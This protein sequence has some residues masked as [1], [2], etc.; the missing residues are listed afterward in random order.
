MFF[1]DYPR[2]P[3][4]ILF[5]WRLRQRLRPYGALV[6]REKSI[7]K[8]EARLGAETFTALV[9]DIMAAMPD[10][11]D[12]DALAGLEILRRCRA[13]DY[14]HTERSTPVFMRTARGELHIRREAAALGAN[15]YFMAGSDDSR[16]IDTIV[17]LVG[18][19]SNAS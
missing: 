15:G 9:L 10:E 12:K 16:L 8:L 7:H 3:E 17:L 2:S 19:S 14:Q 18:G 5:V 6:V 1:D 11:T 13:G 4:N